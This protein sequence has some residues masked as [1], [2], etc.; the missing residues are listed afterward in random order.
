[1]LCL[2]YFYVLSLLPF[3]VVKLKSPP[4]LMVNSALCSQ[5]LTMCNNTTG[6]GNQPRTE[7]HPQC[8]LRSSPEN[9]VS[10][11]ASPNHQLSNGPLNKVSVLQKARLL[12]PFIVHKHEFFILSHP[13][14]RPPRSLPSS[15]SPTPWSLSPQRRESP[16]AT[17]KLSN[18]PATCT[19]TV[20]RR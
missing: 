2:W 17:R 8:F 3:I 18:R 11:Q 6:L 12:R 19:L 5:T 4:S 13:L 14:S 16:P 15:S 9:R 7:I 10:P 20:C 1:M